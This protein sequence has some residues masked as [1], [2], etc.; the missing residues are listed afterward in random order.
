[1]SYRRH[2]V[3]LL[4]WLAGVSSVIAGSKESAVRPR[5]SWDT[6]PQWLIV[7]K[8][9]AFTEEESRLIAAAPLVVFEKANGYKDAGSVED[10]ILRAAR[11]VKAVDSKTVTL[12]YWN[13]VI[14]YSNYRANETFDKNK[15]AWAL[16]KNG[17][18]FL[19]KD[20]YPIYDLLDRGLQDWWI[21]T[22]KA[23][24]SDPAIDGIMIDAICKTRSADDGRRA[25][26]PSTEYGRA[27]FATATRLKAE[28]EGIWT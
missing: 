6:V 12:F 7:R 25:I 16:K 3:W 23:M 15:D 28:V 4:V 24:V 10:G 22:A 20:R 5:F 8:A 14:N 21:A 18:T 1:M 19:F 9:T 26:Y 17:R 2:T 27:Y 13:A 11:A